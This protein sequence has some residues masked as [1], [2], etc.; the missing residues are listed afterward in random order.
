[1]NPVIIVANYWS[2]ISNCDANV[3]AV[4]SV[5]IYAVYYWRWLTDDI[6]SCNYDRFVDSGLLCSFSSCE[7]E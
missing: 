4:F 6:P 2:H 3:A 5:F 1:M 7:K